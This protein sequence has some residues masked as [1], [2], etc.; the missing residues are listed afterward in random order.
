MDIATGVFTAMNS[1]YYI[2]TFGLTA[3]V[4]EN[5]KTEI[6]IH[7]N[8]AEVA[9]SEWASNGGSGWMQDQGSRTVVILD[10]FLPLNFAQFYRVLFFSLIFLLQILHLLAGDTVELRTR[11]DSNTIYRITLCLYMA[12]APYNL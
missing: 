1:G 10:K 7:H 4:E 2:V 8:G 5:E 12:P 6:F 3:F 11:K 9:E